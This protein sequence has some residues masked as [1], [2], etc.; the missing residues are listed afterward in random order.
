M[1]VAY[2]FFS[3]ICFASDAVDGRG[4]YLGVF[5]GAGSSMGS[6]VQQVGTVITPT[7]RISDINVNA[8]GFNGSA[9]ASIAGI[10]LGYEWGAWGLMNSGWSLRP[11]AELEGIYL[12]NNSDG[13]LNIMPAALGTQYVTLPMSAKIVLVNAVL[14]MKTPFS[15]ILIPY[16][17]GGVG[18]AWL[19]VNGSNST[20]PTEPGINH[21][22][23][24]PD[25]STSALALQAKAGIRGQINKNWAIFTEYRYLS[26]QSS[27]YTFGET[28]YPGVHL[29]T[30][31]WNVNVGRQAYNLVTAGIEFSFN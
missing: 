17:G 8:N 12:S 3:G 2:Y 11:A 29:P 5:G 31:S 13:V 10:K 28:N 19:S 24:N 25:A 7:K 16:I 22:N 30:T 14:S 23:S 21:F 20:N 26:I 15:D 9:G 1:I 6:S 4:S 18:R 27:S